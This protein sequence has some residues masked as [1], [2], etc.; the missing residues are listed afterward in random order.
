M[1]NQVEL[2]V[3][4]LKKETLRRSFDLPHEQLGL[5]TAQWIQELFDLTMKSLEKQSSSSIDVDMK[6]RL[7]DERAKE[8]ENKESEL[9]LVEKKIKDCN[10][11]LACKEKEL[12]FV[13]KR[14]GVCNNRTEQI[15]LKEREVRESEKEL[16]LMKEQKASIRAMIEACTEKLEAIEESYDAV[17]AK[18][19]SEKRELELT[20]TFMKDLLV[21]LRLYED[22]LQSLQ[23]TVRLRENELECK[24]K[25]LELKER[26]FCRI[27][28][29]IEE[30]WRKEK[31]KHLDSLKKDLEDR[32]QDLEIKERQFEERVREFELRER[33]FDSL[34]KAVEDSS[35]N[36]E[37]RQK[38]LSDIL[39]LHPKR[40]AAPENL[41]SSG[42]NLQI[43]LNQHL[44]R[45][46]VIFCNVFDTIRKAADPALLVLD[47]MSGFYP[48]HSREGYVEFDV[49]IIRR[50]CILLL[51]QLSSLA[52]EINSQVQGEALKVA[53]EWKKNME[54]TVKDSLVVLGFLHLLAAYKLASAFDGNEL[55][56][57][58]DIVA[59]H[60]Q[61]PKLR[62]SLGFADEV[63]VMHHG[64]A[65]S[66][67]GEQLQIQNP[68]KRP[69]T[70]T[71]L[72]LI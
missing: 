20:Q 68:Y 58:L 31:E 40:S 19:E 15:E 48:P 35:K 54:D 62:R 11:E 42:R 45:H 53:V 47:A 50:T 71:Y 21:K 57:L 52:P 37:L 32:V 12:G 29:R 14:I 6:I 28:E 9:V 17:K 30:S 60:R 7:L 24:E 64:I 5:F 67:S 4:E 69:R 16:V 56:S 38:K 49:S 22:N 61:T 18:L 46:D 39:Q 43:L 63:P 1:S 25:E 27:Q 51:E 72:L 33:E 13:R 26:E 10:F 23:S 3:A 41:T 36:L 65:T 8:I 34:R 59:N 55:A 66:G 70:E 44:R 2:R